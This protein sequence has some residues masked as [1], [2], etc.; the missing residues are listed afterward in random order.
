MRSA[1]VKIFSEMQS[2]RKIC[3]DE[4]LSPWRQY[5]SIK[6]VAK[7]LAIRSLKI[8]TVGIGWV[9]PNVRP[10]KRVMLAAIGIHRD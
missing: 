6:G 1:A 9:V 7:H 2:A 3:P 5:P 10:G 8:S 4:Q